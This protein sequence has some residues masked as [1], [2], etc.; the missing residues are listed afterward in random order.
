VDA[1]KVVETGVRPVVDI[2]MG[3]RQAGVGMVGMG[4]VSPPLACFEN[5]VRA[6]DAK[7]A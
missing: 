3:H 1:R 2:M 5:A 4:I 6:L 7:R